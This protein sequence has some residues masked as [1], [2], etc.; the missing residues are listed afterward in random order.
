M[1]CRNINVELLQYGATLHFGGGFPENGFENAHYEHSISEG[2]NV[3]FHNYQ[4]NW[5]PD[6]IEFSVDDIPVRQHFEFG[7]Q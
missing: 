5:T 2:L 1:M 6:F 7:C 4:V 3:D